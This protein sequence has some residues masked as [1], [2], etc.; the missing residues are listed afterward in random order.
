MDATPG[1][2]KAVADD[3]MK[4]TVYQLVKD[5][6]KSAVEAAIQLGSSGTLLNI[7]NSTKDGKYIFVPF[8]KVDK[9]NVNKYI[10]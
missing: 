10:T 8:E 5:Q 2:C 9:S 7:E 3:S 1:G 6:G 4:L